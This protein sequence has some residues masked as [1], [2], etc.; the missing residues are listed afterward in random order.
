MSRSTYEEILNI[1][2]TLSILNVYP[3]NMTLQ[4]YEI[5]ISVYVRIIYFTTFLVT[6]FKTV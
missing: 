3:H 2:V 6:G 4:F 1:L 5:N